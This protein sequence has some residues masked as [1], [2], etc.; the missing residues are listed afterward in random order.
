MT[1]IPDPIELGEIRAERWA[2]E[3]IK[4]DKYHCSCGRVCSLS[5]VETLSPDPYAEPYCPVCFDE[6]FHGKEQP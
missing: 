1:Y 5:E 6:Y 2:D 3:R 4:G